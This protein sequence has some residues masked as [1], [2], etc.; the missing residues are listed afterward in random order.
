[1]DLGL[2]AFALLLH[3]DLL[4]VTLCERDRCFFIV[5][6]HAGKRQ[7]QQQHTYRIPVR[8]ALLLSTE[9]LQIVLLGQ[10]QNRT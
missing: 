4:N 7:S 3:L 6:G 1:M 5:P 10:L 9:R 8:G 2:A